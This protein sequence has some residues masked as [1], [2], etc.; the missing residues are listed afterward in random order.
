VRGAIIGAVVVVLA[1]WLG[2]VEALLVVVAA[3]V[4]FCIGAI[5][6]GDLDVRGK[7]GR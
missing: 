2:I 4:G 1:G 7:R 6:D 5:I 3:F